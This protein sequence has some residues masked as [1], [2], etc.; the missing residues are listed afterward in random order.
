ML[1]GEEG[2]RRLALM[3]RKR[4]SRTKD[5]LNRASI[6]RPRDRLSEAFSVAPLEMN[7]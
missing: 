5:Y 3:L 1:S 6:L 7:V 4:A 2:D